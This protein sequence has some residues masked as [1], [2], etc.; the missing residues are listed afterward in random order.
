MKNAVVFFLD[1]VELYFPLT[2]F[3]IL[4]LTFAWSVFSRYILGRPCGWATDVE[5]GCYIW[6]VLLAASYVMRKDKHVRFSIVYDM[7]NPRIQCLMRVISNLLIVVPFAC[8]LG[9]TYRYIV[10][11]KTI[12]PALQLPLSFYYAPILW[13]IGSVMLYALRDLIK[14]ILLLAGGKEKGGAR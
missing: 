2:A 9:P 11:L 7:M 8:L 6:T 5:L 1:L 4:F 10:H 14:D 13:F 12:S 3:G